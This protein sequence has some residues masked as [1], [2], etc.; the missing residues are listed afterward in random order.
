MGALY[1]TIWL[2]LLALIPLLVMTA[3]YS[4]VVYIL[5]FKRNE[6]NEVVYQQKGV[7]KVRKRV[8][9]S[10]I[11]VSAIFGA[12][13]ITGLLIYILSYFDIFIFGS[14]SYV[15]S[16]TIFMFNSAINPYIYAL[17]NE[18]FRDK[19]KLFCSA[20]SSNEESGFVE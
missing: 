1:D 5:W 15:V 20:H 16:D 19:L 8:T 12:C 6:Q 3:V 7:L 18:R 11:T 10:V 2:V 9:L 13:W 17:L 4:K 14:I